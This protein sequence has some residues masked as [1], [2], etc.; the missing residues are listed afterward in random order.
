MIW[1]EGLEPSL[2]LEVD[3]TLVMAVHSSQGYLVCADQ[4]GIP[5]GGYFYTDSLTKTF[6]TAGKIA[7]GLCGDTRRVHDILETQGFLR[8][9]DSSAFVLG[10]SLAEAI[11]RKQD[12]QKTSILLADAHG[13][14]MMSHQQIKQEQRMVSPITQREGHA[15]VGYFS[16][17]GRWFVRGAYAPAAPL[18]WLAS[19]M[20]LALEVTNTVTLAVSQ[21]AAATIHGVRTQGAVDWGPADTARAHAQAIETQTRL[22]GLLSAQT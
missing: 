1:D 9:N 11:N 16:D 20:L 5:G 17:L 15:L 19:S 8:R 4:R 2:A 3:M 6:L 21:S 10:E 12:V 14:Y 13:V 18:D 7:I 22:K